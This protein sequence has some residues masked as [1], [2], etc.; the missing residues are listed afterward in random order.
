MGDPKSPWESEIR[1]CLS[2]LLTAAHSESQREAAPKTI[3]DIWGKYAASYA[4]ALISSSFMINC[5]LFSLQA[6]LAPLNSQNLDEH[7][8]R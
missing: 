5:S 7:L 1:A 8:L 3:F 4:Q 6:L 2:D